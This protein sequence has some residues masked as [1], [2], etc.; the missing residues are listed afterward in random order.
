M[1][2]F[3]SWCS[4]ICISFASWNPSCNFLPLNDYIGHLTKHLDCFDIITQCTCCDFLFFYSFLLGV[5]K[6][7]YIAKGPVRVVSTAISKC[8]ATFI[9]SFTFAKIDSIKESAQS[10]KIRLFSIRRSDS[11]VLQYLTLSNIPSFIFAL[12]LKSR[13]MLFAFMDS[14]H[15]V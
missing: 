5:Q 9:Q 10:S 8:I 1:N 14:C 11:A 13:I 2:F 6:F 12:A 15:V 3:Y 4:I 7:E